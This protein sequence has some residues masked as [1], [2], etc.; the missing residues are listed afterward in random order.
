M[1]IVHLCGMCEFI[2]IILDREFFDQQISIGNAADTKKKKEKTT[3]YSNSN[4]SSVDRF[5]ASF[6]IQIRMVCNRINQMEVLSVV[7]L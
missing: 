6:Y 5:N 4:K 1:D 3:T 2:E 7:L